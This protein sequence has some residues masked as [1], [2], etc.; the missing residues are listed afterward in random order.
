MKS[1]KRFLALLLAAALTVPAGAPAEFPGVGFPEDGGEPGEEPAE[2]PVEITIEAGES[3]SVTKDEAGGGIR[4]EKKKP[5]EDEVP[6]FLLKALRRDPEQLEKVY[7]ETV[8]AEAMAKAIESDT[9]F[10][11]CR[12]V[13]RIQDNRIT[14]IRHY[15]E[16]SVPDMMAD[17]LALNVEK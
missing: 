8:D 17:V 11:D 15:A 14:E 13:V 6:P 10:E 2:E 16:V 12:T 3:V 7:A 9:E 4:F 1:H 5:A